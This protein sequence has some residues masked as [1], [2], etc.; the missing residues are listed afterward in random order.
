M[1]KILL[2]EHNL[3]HFSELLKEEAGIAE[4]VTKNCTM[5]CNTVLENTKTAKVTKTEDYVIRDGKFGITI[6]GELPIVVSYRYV[7][8]KSADSYYENRGA[9]SFGASSSYDEKTIILSFFAISG[10][11]DDRA[12][13][14]ACQHELTHM[15]SSTRKEKPLLDGK[16]SRLYAIAA[17]NLTSDANGGFDRMFATIVYMSFDVEQNAYANGLYSLVVNNYQTDPSTMLMQSDA[18]RMLQWLK[19]YDDFLKNGIA[20]DDVSDAEAALVPYKPRDISWFE[21]MLPKIIN[22]FETRLAKAFYKARNDARDK[23]LSK[24]GMF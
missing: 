7:N 15:Y 2:K 17:R 11:I 1:A 10:D 19:S 14:D 13:Y 6:F 22:R 24:G 23:F 3:R 18:Y 16:N 12:L 4:I 8:F 5:L 9:F 21:R 20:N